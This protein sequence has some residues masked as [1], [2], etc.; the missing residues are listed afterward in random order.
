[1][2]NALKRGV[3]D[4]LATCAPDDV[5]EVAGLRGVAMTMGD[6]IKVTHPNPPTQELSD[7]FKRALESPVT[8]TLDPWYP[9][10]LV[11]DVGP[12]N[13]TALCEDQSSVDRYKIRSRAS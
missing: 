11:E 3:A 10:Q 5:D 13:L 12:E 1:M 4:F 7:A 6:M 2:P 8:T 9:S